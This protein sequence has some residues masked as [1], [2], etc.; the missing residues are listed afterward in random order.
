MNWIMQKWRW[1]IKI[2]HFAWLFPKIECIFKTR[3][4]FFLHIKAVLR[5]Y[6]FV[7]IFWSSPLSVSSEYFFLENY[8]INFQDMYIAY[9][10]FTESIYCFLNVLI[11]KHLRYLDLVTKNYS[12]TITR[13]ASNWFNCITRISLRTVSSG[14]ICTRS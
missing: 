8:L 7:F 13:Y 14:I 2:M 10:I 3:S 6:R 11:F 12:S 1:F 4:Q 5:F 9:G